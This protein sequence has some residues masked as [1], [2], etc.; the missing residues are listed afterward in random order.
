M[1]LESARCLQETAIKEEEEEEK[2]RNSRS[3]GRWS[4][5]PRTPT[6]R[7]R[8]RRTPACTATGA[9]S[10]TGRN[11]GSGTRRWWP[12]CPSSRGRGRGVS[13]NGRAAEE[14]ERVLAT[15]LNLRRAAASAHCSRSENG[16][17]STPAC[18][19]TTS[20]TLTS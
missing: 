19:P 8:T 1:K 10:R 12:R 5:G 11:P 14:G 18:S 20:P 2:K 9:P 15:D 3:K 6:W 7:R 4:P 16:N 13:F 17:G